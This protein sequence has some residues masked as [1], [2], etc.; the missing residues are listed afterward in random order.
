ML[1]RLRRI[2]KLI[3]IQKESEQKKLKKKKHS[4]AFEE[5]DIKQKPEL[6]LRN[7]SP[8]R[9]RRVFVSSKAPM[10]NSVLVASTGELKELVDFARVNRAEDRKSKLVKA[11]SQNQ[12]KDLEIKVEK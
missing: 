6:L 8:I 9:R 11:S 1:E 7:E 12:S 2:Q 4:T 5:A 10:N 3:Q